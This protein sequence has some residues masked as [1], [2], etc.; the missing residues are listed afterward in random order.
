MTSDIGMII[1]PP[2]TN[3]SI[4]IP[5]NLI[6]EESS[7][8]EEQCILCYKYKKNLTFNPCGH[9]ISCSLCYSKLPVNKCPI[10]RTDISRVMN[11]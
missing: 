5:D 11:I 4:I 8:E 6:L 9:T 10:C 3:N 7:N 2:Q 1:T